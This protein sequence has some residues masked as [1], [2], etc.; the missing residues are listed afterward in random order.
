[1]NWQKFERSFIVTPA[2]VLQRMLY[3]PH[4]VRDPGDG[5]YI[6]ITRDMLY[7]SLS[8]SS[9][10]SETR[11][12]RAPP[13]PGLK[14]HL[15]CILCAAGSIVV[16]VL[17]SSRATTGTI[18][19]TA[20]GQWIGLESIELSAGVYSWQAANN[21]FQPLLVDTKTVIAGSPSPSPDCTGVYILVGVL[22]G[23]PHY[24]RQSGGYH[25]Y[26]IASGD[27]VINAVAGAEFGSGLVNFW[28]GNHVI[29]GTYES[30]G[31]VNGYAVVN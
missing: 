19:F 31:A 29:N 10:E 23:Q 18:T 28:A 7:C 17:D 22:N 25:L 8:S 14:A 16:T 5:G 6:D 26:A 15:G 9:S 30:Q 21:P 2:N 27:F 11:N 24:A 3:A 13:G 4:Q 12:F 20:A 1:V